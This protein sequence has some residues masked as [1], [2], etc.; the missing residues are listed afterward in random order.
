MLTTDNRWEEFKEPWNQFNERGK[1]LN[2]SLRNEDANKLMNDED[3]KEW[4]NELSFLEPPFTYDDDY[5]KQQSL[6]TRAP[7]STFSCLEGY[8]FR[9]RNVYMAAKLS[10]STQLLLRAEPQIYG[11][12]RCGSRSRAR[13]DGSVVDQFVRGHERTDL[14]LP[15]L[16]TEVTCYS[17]EE[18]NMEARRCYIRSS[19]FQ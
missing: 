15:L 14:L 7:P 13:D 3:V 6:V 16:Q 18:L 1:A 4:L 17:E 5:D 8:F 11:G 19:Y 10:Q 9:E 2:N 12:R